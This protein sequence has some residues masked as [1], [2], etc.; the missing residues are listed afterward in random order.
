M[1]PLRPR[2][3]YRYHP[4]AFQGIR[5]LKI[6]PA[7]AEWPDPKYS[8][9]HMALGS[10]RYTY[11]T[12]SY[13]WGPSTRTLLRL[14]NKEAIS[15]TRRLAAALPHIAREC[16]TGYIWID[17]I[18]IDQNN[19]QER[20]EQVALMGQ[21][22]SSCSK[23]LVWLGKEHM[24]RVTLAALMDHEWFGRAW[25]FQ[26]IVLAPQSR[27][28]VRL[29]D[30]HSKSRDDEPTSLERLHSLLVNRPITNAAENRQLETVHEMLNQWQWEHEQFNPAHPI[31]RTLSRLSPHAKTSNDLDRLYAF[32]GLHMGVYLLS[33]EYE[34]P[35]SHA[36]FSTAKSII[37][38]SSTLD[39]LEVVPRVKAD[40]PHT[41]EDVPLPSS[42]I[43]PRRVRF[44]DKEV[45]DMK[46]LAMHRP[47][48]L[49]DFS[50]PELVTPF[51]TSK[52]KLARGNEPGASM[53]PWNG[54]FVDNKL[55]TRGIVIDTV[56]VEISSPTEN[57]DS[58]I[59]SLY[60]TALR[61]WQHHA[62]D[63]AQHPKP[64]LDRL[65]L[66][67]LS[68]GYCDALGVEESVKN[69]VHR[70]MHGRELWL[71]EH[72]R[73]ACGSYL[74]EKDVICILHGASNPVAL[75]RRGKNTWITLG[76]CYL[77]GWMDPWSNEKCD[78]KD[79]NSQEFVLL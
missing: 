44:A 50:L 37:E 15:I 47:S 38:G 22:Y 6:E 3:S 25:I 14:A 13:V 28:L 70:A 10:T 76:S 18:C 4:L 67:L 60:E 71:T 65:Q 17:Q 79:I 45:S 49:P 34:V 39:I 20:G 1:A 5:L 16:A 62:F 66:A 78:W 27:F 21:I 30:K 75:R 33:P 42:A 74:Q 63:H 77:E 32:F 51:R 46:P 56:L 57:V 26:E 58:A 9:V 64:S 23:V 68:E 53:L 36:L 24:E 48:W 52:S 43:H 69:R 29:E 12:L 54:H 35:F 31:E 72:A 59:S 55:H 2:P 61:I 8:I 40:P 11:E 19:V 41:S 73:F 7:T